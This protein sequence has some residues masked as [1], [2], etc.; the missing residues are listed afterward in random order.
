[1]SKDV[2][3]RFTHFTKAISEVETELIQNHPEEEIILK[4]LNVYNEISECDSAALYTM[5]SNEFIFKLNTCSP[6][7]QQNNFERW[8]DR[9]LNCG[10]VAQSLSTSMITS[11]QLENNDSK[12]RLLIIPLI[13]NTG[14]SGLVV[15]HLNDNIADDEN[16]F[17]YLS[18]YSKYFAMLMYNENL[19]TEVE[20]IKKNEEQRIAAKTNDI[21]QSTRELKFILD[22]IQAGVI[23]IE[24]VTNEIADANNA[25]LKL[26][27]FRKEEI[28]GIQFESLFISKNNDFRGKKIFTNQEAILK[29]N[30]GTIIPVLKT[31]ADI[32]LGGEEFTILTFLDISERKKMEEALEEA[33]YRLEQ[34]VEE[35]TIQ[36]SLTN[37]ELQNQIAKRIQA[38]EEKLKLYWAVQQSPVAIIITDIYG[39]IEYVNPKFTDIT[40]YIY[41]EVLGLSP[42][43]LEANDTSD[44]ENSFFLKALARGD[45]WYGEYKNKKKDGTLVWVSS[46]VSPVENLSGNISHFLVVQE[47][48]TDK[49]NAEMELM[50]AK[51]KAE[52]SD[53]LKG[54]I[55]ANMQHEFRTPLIGIQG[56][57]QILLDDIKDEVQSEML[58][59]IYASGKRLLNTLNSVLTLS[60]FESD[61]ISLRLKQH[62]LSEELLSVTHDF[63][64]AA[65]E[66]GLDFIL[67]EGKNIYAYY[68]QELLTNALYNLIDNAIKFTKKGSVTVEVSSTSVNERKC[69]SVRITDTGIGISESD[70]ELIF[71]PFRQASEG[72][73]RNYEGTGLGLT[74]SKR[75]IESMNGK[76]LL[77]SKPSVGSTFTVLIPA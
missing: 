33:H 54:I 62:N 5:N 24:K 57:A 22:T 42:K 73:S 27:G 44:E 32:K 70:H 31:L 21:V 11:H 37:Q 25:A 55:L 48:I 36:L 4:C 39:K 34:R 77:E 13:I 66:K 26:S 58:N 61:G 29:R 52:Q 76:I 72:Y 3:N 38:E 43:F 47:D 9:L 40:G 2:I 35:R 71:S 1:M 10:A 20:S 53:R 19:L 45:T 28:I 49:K 23:I 74:L 75:M 14:V 51:Q 50:S 12:E 60:K 56:F 67:S 65:E 8:F 63:K 17:A 18:L 30:D 69:A 6:S 41:N 15:L 59:S 7:E 68:D 46:I 64:I 16:T